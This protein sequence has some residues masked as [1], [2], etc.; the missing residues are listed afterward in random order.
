MF[1]ANPGTRVNLR[2][3]SWLM[4]AISVAL[5]LASWA[6]GMQSPARAHVGSAE[7]AAVVDHAI[8]R[9]VIMFACGTLLALIALGL[10]L[11]SLARPRKVL[12]IIEF[13][14]MGLIPAL[15]WFLLLIS[16]PVV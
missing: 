12:R 8:T 15:Q 13:I 7:L 1:F 4:A 5:P 9:A 10:N 16:V 3:A 2:K 14:A 11:R 6:W